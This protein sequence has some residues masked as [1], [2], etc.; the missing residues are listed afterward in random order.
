MSIT[1]LYNLDYLEELSSGDKEFEM[2]MIRYFIENSPQVLDHMDVLN[3][4]QDWAMFR[5]VIHKYTPNM[6]LIG[7]S[8]L[9]DTANKLELHAETKTHLD[10]IPGMLSRIREDVIKAIEQLKTDFQL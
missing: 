4:H 10:E 2:E 9:I 1:K 8:T 7:V 3:S 6:N 5:E